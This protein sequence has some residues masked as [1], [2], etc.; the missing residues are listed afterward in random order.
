MEK[1]EKKIFKKRLIKNKIKIP[2]LI[3]AFLSVLCSLFL[4]WNASRTAEQS[5]AM[6]NVITNS[7]KDNIEQGETVPPMFDG[8]GAIRDPSSKPSSGKQEIEVNTYYLGIFVR[9]SGHLL[10][11]T[12]L[13]FFITLTLL[14]HGLKND[15]SFFLGVLFGV[16]NGIIDETVQNF[17]AGR[18]GRVSDVMIDTCGCIMGAFFAI[19]LIIAILTGVKLINRFKETKQ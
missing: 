3:L 4:L 17:T 10:G 6:S 9:K 5:N 16:F 11:Y 18:T 13:A 19:L 14:S 12:G 8:T 1:A 2:T 15:I 7:I